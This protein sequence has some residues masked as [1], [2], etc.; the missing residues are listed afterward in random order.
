MKNV[1]EHDIKTSTSQKGYMHGFQGFANVIKQINLK[2]SKKE[3]H[4]IID[5]WA[6]DVDYV[7]T[8]PIVD[9]INS[10]VVEAIRRIQTPVLNLMRL[11]GMEDI[12]SYCGNI[13][14]IADICSIYQTVT[15]RNSVFNNNKKRQNEDKNEKT[16]Q[17]VQR[18]TDIALDFNGGSGNNDPIDITPIDVSA[19]ITDCFQ[20]NES[21]K[22]EFNTEHFFRF[23]TYEI[24]QKNIG[25]MLHYMSYSMNTSFEKRSVEGSISPLQKVQSLKGR[26]FKVNPKN[27][28]AINSGQTIERNCIYLKKGKYFRVMSI[29]KKSYNKWRHER[30]GGIKEKMKVHLQVLET[31][32]GAYHAHEGYQYICEELSNLGFYIGHAFGSHK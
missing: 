8:T 19:I 6:V 5:T 16:D 4:D 12:S 10:K 17:M 27:V 14:S 11:Y 24:T 13:N 23:V 18:L 31:Y 2:L 26:W 3:K 22:E 20:E 29:F 15:H 32:H 1:L 28:E 21:I 30:K 7:S 25:N 9:Q